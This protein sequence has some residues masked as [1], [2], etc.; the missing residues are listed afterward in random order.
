MRRL[1]A[2]TILLFGSNFNTSFT[3]FLLCMFANLL[4]TNFRFQD[5]RFKTKVSPKK[6]VEV[7]FYM[8]FAIE[9]TISRKFKVQLIL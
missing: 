9:N 8:Y 2:N 6:V 3:V 5:G 1:L 4:D 7:L